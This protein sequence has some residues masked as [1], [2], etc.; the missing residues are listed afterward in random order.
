MALAADTKPTRITLI[1]RDE[2]AREIAK[3]FPV[4]AAVWD[5]ATGLIAD[6][7]TIRDNLVTAFGNNTNA[8][9]YRAFIT[10]AQTDD[11]LELGAAGSN[12]T[13]TA[14]LVLNLSTAGKQ[15]GY[16]FPAPVIGMFTGAT[17][18]NRNVVDTQDATLL[19]FTEML[20]LTDGKFT[21][22]DGEKLTD[23]SAEQ[24]A[25]GKRISRKI[26]APKP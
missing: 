3:E 14:S 11:T 17:G 13:D 8:L 26:K 21:V 25:S 12:L 18:K 7:K 9:I 24:V 1:L 22:S 20:S 19:T 2:N 10:L 15:T 5:P 23:T 4:P 16:L 6:L